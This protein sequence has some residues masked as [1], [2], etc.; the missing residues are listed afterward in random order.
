[1]VEL[2]DMYA[3]GAYGATRAGSNPVLGTH[4]LRK[5]TRGM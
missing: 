4:A 1:M 3:W 2:V 5:A